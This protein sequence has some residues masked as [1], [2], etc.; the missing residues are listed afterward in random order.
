MD[1]QTFINLLKDGAVQGFRSYHIF[2]SVTIAQAILE[3][4]WGQ[5]AHG[6]NLFGIKWTEGCGYESQSLPTKECIN[7]VWQNVQALFRAY[8]T[9]GDSIFDHAKLLTL[10]RYA[11]VVQAKDY[12]EACRAL[13][14]CGYAN[15]PNY[16]NLL[17]RIIE[18]NNLLQYDNV[19]PVS[20]K[21]MDFQKAV[22]DAGYTDRNGNKL[23]VDGVPGNLTKSVIEKVILK[24]GSKGK[25]IEWLQQRLIELGFSCGAAGSDGNFGYYTLTAVQ[26]F[27]ALRHLSSDGIVGPLTLNELLK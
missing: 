12:K 26:N 17:I 11:P 2:P 13:H 9:Y 10:G 14:S 4:G 27:Q 19:M 6:N 7:G 25:L 15:D 16:A 24:R 5:Y 20:Q 23:T 18:Q 22:N 8:K 3:S 21:V 1:K